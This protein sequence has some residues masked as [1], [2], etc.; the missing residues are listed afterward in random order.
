MLNGSAP[1]K[2]KTALVVDDDAVVR[3][4]I[5]RM[6]LKMGFAVREAEDGR[7]ALRESLKQDFDI[8]ITDLAMP[9]MDGMAFVREARAGGVAS[10]VIFLTATATVPKAVEAIKLGAYEF[11]E[12]PMNAYRLAEVVKAAIESRPAR[13]EP[14]SIRIDVEPPA[15]GT[16]SLEVDVGEPVTGCV[17][18]EEG[19]GGAGRGL[20]EVKVTR[21]P[22]D[23]KARKRIG[24]YEVES[25]I[26][27]GGMGMV[28][29]CRDPLIGRTV[30]VKVLYLV[31]DE[32]AE[33]KEIVDRFRRE[34]AAAGTLSHPNIVA[35]HDMGRDEEHGDWF[36]VMEHVDGRGLNFVMDEKKA[37]S[38][39]DVIVLGFQMADALAHAHAC[40][41][42]HRDI[43]P[44]NILIQ[45]DGEAKLV[46]FGLAAVRGWKVTLGGRILGSP[47]YMAPERIRGEVGGPWTDQ[48]SLGVVLYESLTGA[49]PFDGDTLETKVLRLL[50]HDPAPLTEVV[51]SV[52]PKLAEAVMR[53]MAKDDHDRF[54]TMQNLADLFMLI[55]RDFD[56]DLKRH[57]AAPR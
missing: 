17:S 28:F 10:P 32:Q 33:A 42:T 16:L 7:S 18:G 30:A 11:L 43:K 19:S 29:K 4:L 55:G 56:L 6:L 36:I 50:Q 15:T 44:S 40:G 46:D 35:V 20:R 39:K 45:S 34:A 8:I 1:Y 21:A 48:F 2:G 22:P 13:Q 9:G 31:S 49:N 3:C 5:G 53:L 12:K 27:R 24:R 38:E 52:S 14:A 47:S 57:I 25:L 23:P 37:L 54:P 51:P 26:G 41:V